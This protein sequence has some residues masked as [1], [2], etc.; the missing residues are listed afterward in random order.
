MLGR[1][2][3]PDVCVRDRP[4]HQAITE[5]QRHA[6]FQT[7]FNLGRD[8]EQRIGG[9]FGP[10]AEVRDAHLGGVPASSAGREIF[11]SG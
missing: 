9:K 8:T 7:P 5:P 10:G 3:R 2:D 4:P 11:R 1:D 6:Y